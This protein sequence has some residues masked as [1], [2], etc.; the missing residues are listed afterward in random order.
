MKVKD[1]KGIVVLVT[2]NTVRYYDTE[3][4]ALIPCR[5]PLD[6]IF[7]DLD[8]V[9]IL[10]SEQH[11][12]IPNMP[13]EKGRFGITETIDTLVEVLLFTDLIHFIRTGEIKPL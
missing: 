12:H 5:A 7:V 9:D 13:I 11:I 3:L 10:E 4:K 1:V 8:E 2:Y 6:I